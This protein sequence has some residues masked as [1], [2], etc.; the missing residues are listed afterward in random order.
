MAISLAV[1]DR[2]SMSLS[3][4]SDSPFTIALVCGGIAGLAA[5]AATFPINVV[6][7]RMQTEGRKG[8][9]CRRGMRQMVSEMVEKEGVGGLYRGIQPHCLKAVVGHATAFA[10]FEMVKNGSTFL[11]NQAFGLQHL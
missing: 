6:Q 3:K 5:T 9:G 8:A 7:R 2:L 11:G 1:Y 4:L 10:T